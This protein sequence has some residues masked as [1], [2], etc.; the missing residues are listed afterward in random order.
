MRPYTRPEDRHVER[1]SAPRRRTLLAGKLACG[2]PAVTIGCGVRNLSE[3]GAQIELES[4]ALVRPPLRLLMARDGVIHEADVIWS[5]G[6]TLGLSFTAT[7]EA[8][9]EV[10]DALRMMRVLWSVTRA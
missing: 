4:P 10:P 5:W 3:R 6:K 8:Q 1:R 7:Y 9:D 2:D